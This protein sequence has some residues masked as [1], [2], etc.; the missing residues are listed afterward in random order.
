MAFF[1]PSVVVVLTS[2]L[3]A[4]ACAADPG[5]SGEVAATDPAPQAP[6]RQV[7]ITIDDLPRG[8]DGGDTSFEGVRA[9]TEAL[10]RPFREQHI[11]VIGFVNQN[12]DGEIGADGLRRILDL[13][14]DA[15]A[16]L[17]NHSASHLNLNTVPLAEYEADILAGEPVVRAALEARGRTLRYYRHPFLFTGPTPEIHDGLQAF[18]DE[19]GY[20]V[21]PVTLDNGDYMFAALYTRDAFRERVRREYVPYME[22]I[23]SFFES[24][25]VE[26]A[27]R[28]FPQVLLIHASR[29]NADLMPDL[30]AMFRRRGYTFVT[31]DQALADPAYQMK[32]GYVGRGGFSWIHRWSRTLGLPPRGEADPPD[33]VTE[34]W[35]RPGAP[36][37]GGAR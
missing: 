3:V 15:G 12:R 31:L 26:V 27:G 20:R 25:S 21:A 9:M 16:D 36:A 32:D 37:A 10:L 29:M 4:S 22:S 18:L 28:E 30:L 8:G 35:N 6:D 33:W 13:W 23:V 11:P 2:V 19:H 24:R 17:G 7:A 1:R 5:G 14:L 34:N